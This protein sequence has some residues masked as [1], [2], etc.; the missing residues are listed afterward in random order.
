MDHQK[1]FLSPNDYSL[2]LEEQIVSGPR[3]ADKIWNMVC[4]SPTLHTLWSKM[5]FGLKVLGHIPDTDGSK[6]ILTL[7]FY[8]FQQNKTL[9]SDVVEPTTEE[10]QRMVSDDYTAGESG[11][12][13]MN[14]TTCRKI[15]TGDCFQITM[16]M[17]HVEKAACM[18]RFIWHLG[19]AVRLRGQAPVPDDFPDE[20]DKEIQA[21]LAEDRGGFEQEPSPTVLDWLKD[22]DA[23]REL[24]RK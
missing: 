14:L 22:V 13:A 17:E 21:V 15:Q 8:W 1:L 2:F 3:G 12:E 11:C 18:F 6:S 24:Q 5:I 16:N 20:D 9:G 19:I 10:L 23:K 4:L 7:Q